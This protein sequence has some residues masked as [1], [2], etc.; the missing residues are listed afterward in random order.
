MHLFIVKYTC[1][2]VRSICTENISND[3]KNKPTI[4]YWVIL[5]TIEHIFTVHI[6]LTNT[7][8]VI[9]FNRR[10]FSSVPHRWHFYNV[11]SLLKLLSHTC[12]NAHFKMKMSSK[13]K[14]ITGISIYI[15][16]DYYWSV[17]H[18]NKCQYIMAI[19]HIFCH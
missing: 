15:T 8:C 13:I 18:S 17:S 4:I 19:A 2:A 5:I 10:V 1:K 16:L 12:W 6:I 11:D 3:R 7:R 14:S 9:L